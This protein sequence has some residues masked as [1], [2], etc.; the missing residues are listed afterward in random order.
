MNERMEE[1]P[2]SPKKALWEGAT[3]KGY[4]QEVPA[5]LGVPPLRVALVGPVMS[6]AGREIVNITL[7]SDDNRLYRVEG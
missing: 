4:S 1:S 3:V 5:V 7:L 2:Q 6:K